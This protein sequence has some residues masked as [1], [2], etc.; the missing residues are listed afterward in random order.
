MNSNIQQTVELQSPEAGLSLSPDVVSFEAQV[1]EFTEAEVRVPIR[2]RNLPA[3]MAVT[4]NP[5]SVMVRF[6]IPLD[7]YSEIQGARQSL[8]GLFGH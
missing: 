2:T 7:Q 4:Y 5:S 1:T 3:G 6:D 8:C